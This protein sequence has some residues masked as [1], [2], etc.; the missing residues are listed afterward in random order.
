MPAMKLVIL[1]AFFTHVVTV[2][3]Q[4]SVHLQ[5][6]PSTGPG[7]C[8]S[9]EERDAAQ[10]NLQGATSSVIQRFENDYAVSARCGPGKW[11][12]VAYLNMSDPTQQCPPFLRLYSANGVKA[13]GRPS[14]IGAF[15]CSSL[16]FASGD[17][18]QYSKV[19]GQV[20]GYQIG[21]TDVFQNQRNS[22]NTGYVDGVSITHGSL[23]R[24]HIWTYAAGLSEQLLV[25]YQIYSCPCVVAGSSFSPQMPP[26]YVGNNYYCESG[27]PSST[28][29]STNSFRYTSDPIWDGQQCEGQCCSDGRT[30][31][32]FS[33]TLTNPTTDD[34]EVRIC[35]TES[36][37]SEDTPISLMELYV[38]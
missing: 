37:T 3:S 22:I 9:Q 29:D 20:I 25:D 26:S 34:I 27:N 18:R 13:C 30:P 7:V 12:R 36:T 4:D 28:F 15:G 6:I 1:A 21:N 10:Q 2:F 11:Y 24:W 19:C 23:P 35:G 5:I 17:G 33:V 32:W 16:S 38:Q 31:P 14:T 8:A